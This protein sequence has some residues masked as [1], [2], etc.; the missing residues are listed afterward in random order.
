MICLIKNTNTIK[1]AFSDTGIGIDKKL[2]NDVFKPFFTSKHNKPGVGLSIS[3]RI[4]EE[5]GGSISVSSEPGKLTTFDVY[6][7]P[8]IESKAKNKEHEPDVFNIKKL[9]SNRRRQK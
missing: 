1:L 4:I 9:N 5:H 8:V 3:K 7:S 6:L 2:I